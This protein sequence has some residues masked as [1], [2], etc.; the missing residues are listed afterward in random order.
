MID[1]SFL[2]VP[3]NRPD[4]FDKARAA[5]ADVTLIESGRGPWNLMALASSDIA[6]IAFGSI[7]FPIDSGIAG[8]RDEV[9]F[10]RSQIVRVSRLAG[11]P[12]AT[13]IEW[14]QRVVTAASD[15]RDIAVRVDGK[16]VD[17]P[18]IERARAI[19][20]SARRGAK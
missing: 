6:R 4:R 9:L 11:L 12:P 16:L 18:V 10:A 17:R 3:G 5:G 19:V 2:S 20:A 13:D 1:R 14:A 15:V 8:E 7:E